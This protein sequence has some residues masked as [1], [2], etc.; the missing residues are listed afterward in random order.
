MVR[1]PSDFAQGPTSKK[2]TPVAATDGRSCWCYWIRG[3]IE[4]IDI[5]AAIWGCIVYAAPER[6][7]AFV[8]G[9]HEARDPNEVIVLCTYTSIGPFTSTRTWSTD[10]SQVD[11]KR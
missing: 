6:H 4:T 3:A 1:R 5:A 7:R 2:A 11:S 8:N 9:Y 10:F